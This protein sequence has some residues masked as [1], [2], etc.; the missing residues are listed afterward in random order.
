[1]KEFLHRCQN[2]L[3]HEG[4]TCISKIVDPVCWAR[5]HEEEGGLEEEGECMRSSKNID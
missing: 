4:G 2:L 1:M 5:V 3:S